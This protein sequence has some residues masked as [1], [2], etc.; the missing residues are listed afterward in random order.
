MLKFFGMKKKSD[1]T[2]KQLMTLFLIMLIVMTVGNG[3]NIQTILLLDDT[4]LT[5]SNS[6]TEIKNKITKPT[7]NTESN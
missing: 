6:T 1:V 7:N 3:V 4:A 5:P 2:F